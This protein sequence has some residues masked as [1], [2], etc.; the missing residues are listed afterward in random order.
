MLDFDRMVSHRG[1]HL[2]GVRVQYRPITGQAAMRSGVF[3]RMHV[4]VGFGQDGA[5]VSASQSRIMTRL[6]EWGDP[7]QGDAVEVRIRLGRATHID[8]TPLP[9]DVVLHYLVSDV[10]PDSIGGA[11]L[12][13]GARSIAD[14]EE[15]PVG[16]PFGPGGQIV[17]T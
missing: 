15:A 1:T 8:A 16:L 6:A 12:I 2:Y 3:D 17:G 5:V 14:G 10:Q 4:E 9:G 13:L 7:K 11:L